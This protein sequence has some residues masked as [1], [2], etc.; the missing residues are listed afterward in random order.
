MQQIKS[1]GLAMSAYADAGSVGSVTDPGQKFPYLTIT[2]EGEGHTIKVWKRC[3]VEIFDPLLASEPI[4]EDMKPRHIMLPSEVPHELWSI[5]SEE[6]R[7]LSS[8]VQARLEARRLK[9]IN[10]ILYSVL[11]VIGLLAVI[12]TASYFA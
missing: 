4:S 11:G 2:R 5:L 3:R 8:L 1:P 7:L 12:W 9:R 10:E 6:E